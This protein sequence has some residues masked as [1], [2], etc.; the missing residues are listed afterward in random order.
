MLSLPIDNYFIKNVVPL[1]DFSRTIKSHVK[2]TYKNKIVEPLS[3]INP[4]QI[5]SMYSPAMVLSTS[6]A[7]RPAG[8]VQELRLVDEHAGWLLLLQLM[9]KHT[10]LAPGATYTKDIVFNGYKSASFGGTSTLGCV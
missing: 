3:T 1:G 4:S 6:R 8:R 10:K 5:Q 7:R 2:H 9:N